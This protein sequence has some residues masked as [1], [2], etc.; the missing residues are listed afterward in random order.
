MAQISPLDLPTSRDYYAHLH[1]TKP[2]EMLQEHID[3]VIEY[4]LTLIDYH[5]IDT[6]V[7]RLINSLLPE[8]IMPATG[9]YVKKLFL[10]AIVY[11]DYGKINE[12]FQFEKMGNIQFSR[13]LHSRIGTRHSILSAY[14]FIADH[15][16][17]IEANFT[18]K[19]ADLFLYMLTLLSSVPILRHHSSRLDSDL[20]FSD[21]EIKGMLKYLVLVGIPAG[22]NHQRLSDVKRLEKLKEKFYHLL[23]KSVHFPLFALIKLNSSLLTASDYYATLAYRMDLQ[24][25]DFGRLT[26]PDV[27]RLYHKF[28]EYRYN[29]DTVKDFSGIQARSVEELKV[30]CQSNLNLLRSKLLVDAVETVRRNPSGKVFYLEAPTGAGKTNLSLGVALELLK[31]SGTLDKIFYVFPYTTLVTQTFQSIKD[32]LGVSD[33]QIVQLH[34]KTGFHYQSE[35]KQEET[36]GEYQK[37]KN[38]IHNLFV[39]YPIVLMTHVKFFD[40]LKANSKESNYILHRL[41][42]SVVVIDELQSYPPREWDKICY[43]IAEYAQY[44][45]VK[46]ILMSATL[47][48]LDNI[49]TVGLP[50]RFIPLIADKVR[51]FQNPNFRER[52]RFDF[53]WLEVN[54]DIPALAEKVHRV[55]EEYTKQN[56]N[57][58]KAI[59]QFITKKTAGRF[60]RQAKDS[61][62][63][64]DYEI[65]LLSGTILEPRRREIIARIKKQRAGG[66]KILLISTQVIEAGVDIDMDIGFKDRSLIDNEEQLAGR[67]NREAS[68]PQSVVY[69]FNLDREYCVYGKDL[70]YKAMREEPIASQYRRILEE[71][72]FDCLYD[73]V[74]KR[75]DADNAN[76]TVDNLDDYKDHL[77][78][79]NFGKVDSEFRLIEDDSWPVFTPIKVPAKIEISGIDAEQ[80][81]SEQE[82][83][84]LRKFDAYRDEYEVDGE[85][86]WQSY[87]K[88]ISAEGREL[89][90]K[91]MDL[92]QIGGI[93]AKFIFSV[94]GSRFLELQEFADLDEGVGMLYLRRHEEIYDYENGIDDE[95]FKEVSFL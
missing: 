87:R 28:W 3:S 72:D 17:K 22:K 36:D 24:I 76:N 77:R 31:S 80:I 46:F 71:K 69:I 15:F 50:E 41:T 26:R 38:F 10:T 12:N 70:R 32:T 20:K 21:S 23:P 60:L 53:S 9:D 27:D 68:K 8:G 83:N 55:C 54:W 91:K 75:I 59:V 56:Q 88:I 94:H 19:E 89:I 18:D 11:H 44:F 35:E 62:M 7:D 58:V 66:R 48:K 2:P 52:V 16:R 42:N 51:Y 6:T 63:F 74:C 82:L 73:M 67:V 4:A 85:R 37:R 65:Y 30:P 13:D 39:N 45:N 34:S 1:T 57:G 47:P 81:F 29:H 49:R 93:M 5:D 14:L 92:K 95:K 78:K 40:I 84:F 79:T 33:D 25:T 90:D 86:V 64:A 61:G 43:F